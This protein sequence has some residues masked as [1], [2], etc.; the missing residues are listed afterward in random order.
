VG[1]S[2]FATLAEIAVAKDG[3]GNK[4]SSAEADRV[5]ALAFGIA[6]FSSWS[7]GTAFGNSK[8]SHSQLERPSCDVECASCLADITVAI[9]KGGEDGFFF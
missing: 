4:C 3:A 9:A 7:A 6:E 5:V 8:Q 2:C 1:R